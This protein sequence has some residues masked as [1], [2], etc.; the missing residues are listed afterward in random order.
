MGH[1]PQ[2]PNRGPEQA[3][4][5]E[6]PSRKPIFLVAGLFLAAVAGAVLTTGSPSG[7]VRPSSPGQPIAV[8]R[9][10]HPAVHS[11]RRVTTDREH[12]GAGRWL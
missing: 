11:A 4:S 10:T 6:G 8:A 3:R 12:A 2:R 1:R 9:V 7:P 5:V